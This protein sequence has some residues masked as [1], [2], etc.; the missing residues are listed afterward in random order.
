MAYESTSVS[1]P[2]S[3]DAIRKLISRRSN[4]GGARIAVVSDP[5][6]EGFSADVVIDGKTY[7]IRVMATRKVPPSHRTDKQRLT[8]LEQEERRI[9][10][11]IFHHLKSVFEA[12]DSGVMEFRE[13]MMPYIV[14]ANGKTIAEAIL[15][16]LDAK[17]AGKPERLLS[18]DNAAHATQDYL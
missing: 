18:A 14:M 8:F 2:K 4:P 11:V 5:P 16:Q 15:P 17:L 10:R 3:Q 6:R 13:L 9:W 12:A 7:H 1:V